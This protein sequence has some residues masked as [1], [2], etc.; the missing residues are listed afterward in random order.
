MLR[1]LFLLFSVTIV[2]SGYG[3]G[4]SDAGFCTM[5]AMRPSQIYTKKINFKLRSIEVSY[6]QG[7]THLTPTI[8]A[9]TVDF[10]FGFN[11]LTSMQVK[12]PYLWVNGS[13]G[14]TS[15]LADISLSITRNVYTS[16]TYHLNATIGAKIPTNSS[17]LQTTNTDL[18]SDNQPHTLPMYYQT[19]LGSYDFV[20][21]F[22]Y[23]SQ[24][25]MFATGIQMA[26][27]SNQNNFRY[28]DWD[29]YPDQFY[30]QSYDLANQLKRG[31]DIM[32]RAE[33]AFH[34]SKV[35]I[36]L[37]L[38][39]ILRISKDKIIDKDLASDTFD[40]RIK[41][42]NTTGLA[43]SALLNTAYH[44]N[45]NNSVKFM[46]GLKLTDRDVNPDGLTRDS[47]LSLAY[48]ARF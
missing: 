20:A 27:S 33:R 28:E 7:S 5:G 37:G 31:T 47:V 16:D 29:N 42:E 43:L 30:L 22:A 35:D 8:S 46:F 40:E 48:E 3:Q 4:C 24:K 14:K 34:F 12:L 15:D 45:T 32:F 10:N 11:E 9:A 44:F 1:Y 6:Y 23:I 39:P 21:G 41:L 36:R 25:W 13:L 38:L 26:L 17:N 18:T 19:S 2:Y